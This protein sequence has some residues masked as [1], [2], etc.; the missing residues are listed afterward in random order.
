MTPSHL[1]VTSK[2]G[3][4]YYY[5]R[6]PPSLSGFFTKKMFRLSDDKG[7]ALE[8]CRKI[9]A[10]EYQGI[11]DACIDY[12]NRAA[13]KMLSNAIGRSKKKG[14]ECSLDKAHLVSLLRKQKYRCAVTAIPFNLNW[15]DG[16]DAKRNAFAPSLDRVDNSQGYTKENVRMILSALNYAMN[17]W[18]LETYLT[19]ARA[20]TKTKV[21]E[22]MPET[23]APN[24]FQTALDS[25]IL[26]VAK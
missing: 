10:G 24:R 7:E 20:A 4:E 12:E 5:F 25:D 6:V 2:K 23:D 18:G 9:I 13:G 3:R 26:E 8:Q 17:E 21:L 22:N 16:R 14:L 19:I 11:A 1:H 15:R